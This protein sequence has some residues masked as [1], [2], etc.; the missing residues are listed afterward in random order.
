MP[1]AENVLDGR[2]DPEQPNARWCADITYV[3][4]REGWLHL[5][6]V[7]DLFSQMIVG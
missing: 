6:V 5:A 1:V 3:P 7:E 4:T 2:F